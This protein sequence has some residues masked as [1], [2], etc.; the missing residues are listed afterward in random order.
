MSRLRVHNFALS[1][2]GFGVGEGISEAQPFGHA[3]LR[4]HEWM[5]ATEMG[6]ALFGRPGG[7]TGVDNDL[8]SANWDGIGAEI[9]G[10]HKFHT[11]S[12]DMPQ[13]WHGPWGPN[14]PF[15]TPVIVLTHHA[16]PAIP[17]D[18]GTTF[19]FREATPQ[20]A[21]DEARALARGHDVRLGGGVRTV[22]EFLHA[23]LVDHLHLVI[24]P[25]VLGRGQRL[26]DGLEGFEARFDIQIVPGD[27]HVT[28]LI[29]TR[30][31]NH[32]DLG[33]HHA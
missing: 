26:W 21:L 2:D 23:D 19:H 1:L 33:G 24:V 31:N 10:R 4:L 20:Q 8:A 9:M 11:G 29:A 18:G 25:I 22:R 5:S 3:G 28:H 32:E 27:G 15:H 12:G 13:D 17:M 16:R 14:P 7:A 30:A 6:H